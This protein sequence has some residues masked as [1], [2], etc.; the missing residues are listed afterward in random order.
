MSFEAAL[1]EVLPPAALLLEPEAKRPF[2]CDGLSAYC[3]MPRVVCLPENAEQVREV[4]RG[5]G[6]GD[7]QHPRE[8][9]HVALAPADLLDDPQAAGMPEERK[10]LGEFPAGDG[11]EWHWEFRSCFLKCLL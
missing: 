10:D 9:R 4:L 8:R 6:V 7:P 2:E 11:S 1:A 5:P 3:A